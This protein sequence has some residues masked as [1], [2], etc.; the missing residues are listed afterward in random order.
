M[1]QVTYKSTYHLYFLIFFLCSIS[2]SQTISIGAKNFN[3]GFLLSEILAQLL[4]DNGFPVDRKYN[5]GGTLICFEALRNREIDIYPEY[6]GTI[7]EQILQ[8][9]QRLTLFDLEKRMEDE[10]D[11]NISAPLGFNNTY[12]LAV[13]QETAVK[14]ALDCISDL[15]RIPDLVFAFSYEFLKRQDGWKNLSAV[16]QLPQKAVGVE[17]G[18]SYQ[19]LEEGKVDLID[20]YSTDGEIS[21]YQLK[22]LRD[23][24]NFFPKYLAVVL[25]QSVLPPMVKN[26][27]GQLGNTIT[28]EKMQAMNARVVYN[29]ESYARVARSFLASINLISA[30]EQAD[31]TNMY[32]EILDKTGVHLQL[33]GIALI[34]AILIAIPLGIFIYHYE[35]IARPVLYLTGLLQTIPSIAL[36]ALMIPIF[37][38]GF[39]PAVIALF[40]YALLPILRN[41][42]IAL[43]SID[44]LLKKVATGI[45]LTPWQRLRYVEI[46]LSAPTVFAGIKT[47]AVIS[48]GTAT[49]A[50]F[51]GAGG[52]GEFI[53]TGLTLNNTVM[54]L[55]GAVPAALLAIFVEFIFEL[56]EKLYIPKHLQQKLGK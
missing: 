52:L 43:F 36:L 8:S 35:N 23:D 21:R 53:V 46:P 24:L 38:I 50:A 42:T 26:L 14:Y 3:E 51:I 6:T 15:Q 55:K 56:I 4:E 47:A 30:D 19:A 41:T 18:L 25:Y 12:A 48:I 2:F 10:F 22:V 29:R 9:E 49:L 28:E 5:L 16:Y 20:I 13:K 44:P 27:I 11:L 39:L 7:T 54:I 37:G 17:H 33:T 40:L 34:A 31:E 1:K 32:E 45:G